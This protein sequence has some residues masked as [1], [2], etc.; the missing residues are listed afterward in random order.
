MYKVELC[1]D[2]CIRDG[3]PIWYHVCV[4]CLIVTIRSPLFIQFRQCMQRCCPAAGW[5][6][7]MSKCTIDLNSHFVLESVCQTPWSA[8]LWWS[9]YNMNVMSGVV[10]HLWCPLIRESDCWKLSQKIPVW[11]IT[12]YHLYIGDTA[13]KYTLPWSESC[14][15]VNQLSVSQVNKLAIMVKEIHSNN[16][17]CNI[18]ND[19]LPCEVTYKS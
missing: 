6:D 15:L 11:S 14:S 18:S 2:G 13:N 4:Q 8:H 5:D 9:W 10:F 1:E 12:A 7:V 3:L 19:E 16:K 17:L